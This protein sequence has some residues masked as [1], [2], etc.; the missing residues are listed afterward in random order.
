MHPEDPREELKKFTSHAL[1]ELCASALEYV[2]PLQRVQKDASSPTENDPSGQFVQIDAF[3]TENVPFSQ[4]RHSDAAE[5]EYL[6]LAQ[7]VHD[8]DPGKD[9]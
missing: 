4:E 7:G 3:L 5:L 8:L 1:H 9:T 6:P 2:P